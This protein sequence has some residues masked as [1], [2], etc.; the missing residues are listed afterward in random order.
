LEAR[1][2]AK[3]RARVWNNIMEPQPLPINRSQGLML[4]AAVAGILVLAGWLFNL[5]PLGT[6]HA[7][8]IRQCDA[9]AEV[10]EDKQFLRL[11]DHSA[12]TLNNQ[13]RLCY[14]SNFTQGY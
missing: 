12:V 11:P 4:A 5:W 1:R 6:A 2:A 9:G 14:S 7:P 10:F 8:V 3:R 13:S